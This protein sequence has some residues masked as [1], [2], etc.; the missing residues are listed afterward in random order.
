MKQILLLVSIVFISFNVFS[1]D[2]EPDKRLIDQYRSQFHFS[3]DTNRLGNPISMALIDTVYHI[4]YQYNPKSMSNGFVN[5]GHATSSDLV[6]WTEQPVAIKQP[7]T[8]DSMLNSPWWGSV[9]PVENGLKAW[10]NFWGNGIY[11]MNSS[12]GFNWSE[13]VKTTGTDSLSQCEPFVFRHRQTG[14]WLM[15]AYGRISK[16]IYIMTSSDGLD[17]KKLSTF[18]YNYGFPQFFE[19]PVDRKTDDTRWVLL[20]E[21]GTYIVSTFDG[22]NVK[23]SSTV[24]QLNYGVNIGASVVFNDQKNDR[25]LMVSS[26][27]NDPQADS[28][29]NGQLS[30]INEISLHQNESGI[31]LQV[32]PIA[33]YSLLKE[34]IKR[35]EAKKIY[36]GINNNILKGIKSNQL[37]IKGVIDILTCDQF[38]FILRSNRDLE[39]T[40]INFNIKKNKLNLLGTNFDYTPV[41]NKIEFEILIDRAAIEVYIDGGKYVVSNSVVISPENLRHGLYT[42]G[43]EILID[44]LEVS[45]LKS[46]WEPE[47]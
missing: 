39:G 41:N 46:V 17:W 4:Y 2:N 18:H 23:V 42:M 47:K 9:V 45:E 11:C 15:F 33:N 40:E 19:L 27:K 32:K 28:L 30:V 6:N 1:R 20:T 21:K 5:W 24:K 26:L 34:K 3:T 38:G 14:K 12:D 36:P 16:T 7:E 35:F 37:S 22:E 44:W 43:G 8:A 29:I 13:R 25:L 10:V 31:D